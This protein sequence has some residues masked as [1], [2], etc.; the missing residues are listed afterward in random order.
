MMPPAPEATQPAGTGSLPDSNTAEAIL[1][2]KSYMWIKSALWAWDEMEDYLLKKADSLD[3]QI[4]DREWAY[5][6]LAHNRYMIF[7]RSPPVNEVAHL[8]DLFTLRD[9][10]K[11]LSGIHK[12]RE[13]REQNVCW[14]RMKGIQEYVA[15]LAGRG[16]SES[17]WKAATADFNMRPI[18]FDSVHGLVPDMLPGESVDWNEA[19]ADLMGE[20]E[21]QKMIDRLY[22]G[23]GDDDEPYGDDLG[24]EDGGGSE[25]EDDEGSEDAPAPPLGRFW[26]GLADALDEMFGDPVDAAVEALGEDEDECSYAAKWWEAMDADDRAV[27]DELIAFA[28]AMA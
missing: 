20:E 28:E 9:L 19:M 11:C 2:G 5:E 12:I 25:D 13:Y 7:A 10:W 14:A 15:S 3:S 4:M 22:S 17:D 23:L 26:E 24:D 6:I 18:D 21:Y 1:Y 27:V 16:I 8:K